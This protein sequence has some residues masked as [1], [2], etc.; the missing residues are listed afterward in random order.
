MLLLCRDLRHVRGHEGQIY[1]FNYSSPQCKCCLQGLAEEAKR[2]LARCLGHTF[3]MSLSDK[4]PG[5]YLAS[6]SLLKM[7]AGARILTARECSAAVADT[8]PLL[9]E[10]VCTPQVFALRRKQDF[11]RSPLWHTAQS[12]WQ[13]LCVQTGG[14][15]QCEG[16]GCGCRGASAPGREQGRRPQL[17]GG[18]VCEA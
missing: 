13:G 12:P 1:A 3:R 17:S 6:V 15:E 4:V 5:V 8:A 14:R 2:G 9:I 18:P 10:K 11:W 7:L 16:P